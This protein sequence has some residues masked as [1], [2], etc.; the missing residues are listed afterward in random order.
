MFSTT[1]ALT[2]VHRGLATVGEAM[3]RDSAVAYPSDSLLTALERMAHAGVARL[4]VV[5]R[6][7][8]DRLVGLVSL[9]DLASVLDREA[10][11]LNRRGGGRASDLPDPLRSVPVRAAMTHHFEV[12]EAAMPIARVANR[13]ASSGQFAALVEDTAGLPSGIVTLGDLERAAASETPPDQ[14]VG[15]I[16]TRDLVVARPEQTLAEALSQPGAE[17]L[18]QLPVVVTSDGAT[19]VVGMLRR[20]DV[21]AAYLRSRDRESVIARRAHDMTAAAHDGGVTVHDFRV[22]GESTAV[23]ATLG[24]LGLPG[25]VLVTRVIREGILLIPRGDLRLQPGDVLE[26]L[27]PRDRE[28]DLA[29]ILRPASGR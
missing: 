27:A 19:R 14:P 23:G 16:A 20:S 6:A 24:D 11:E 28:S 10:A 3:V 9:H 15:G 2:A 1:D 21:V 26:V 7:S 25:D 4:P 8:P 29:R 17:A 5:D 18:R 13:L 12:V 22:G